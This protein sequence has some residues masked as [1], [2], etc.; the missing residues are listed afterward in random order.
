MKRR[1]NSK[2]RGGRDRDRDDQENNNQ[3]EQR[4]TA[5][6]ENNNNNNR[7]DFSY[8][9]I[10]TSDAVLSSLPLLLH[11]LATDS[12]DL[13]LT[14]G[15]KL[16]NFILPD[17]DY[18]HSQTGGGVAGNFTSLASLKELLQSAGSNAAQH[19][20]Q[21]RPNIPVGDFML[22]HFDANGDGHI[23]RHELLH[24]TEVW[25]QTLQEQAAATKNMNWAAWLQRE[26]PL[27]DWK[28]GVF[29]WSTF[30]GLLLVLAGFSVIPGRTHGITAKILR[31]PVLGVVDFLIVVE[32]V[33]V[34]VYC[35]FV[36]I[37]MVLISKVIS[38][39]DY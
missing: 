3:R 17:W 28:I 11:R 15:H 20:H 33:C 23:S 6:D 26:W 2:R 38:K 9:N 24:M 34:L 8:R 31:W 25:K 18:Y 7:D 13:V 30:G 5:D 12:K 10:L 35:Y 29:L 14:G 19:V 16:W 37:V 39:N 21:A 4:E 36:V 22:R 27:L 32:L 1:D